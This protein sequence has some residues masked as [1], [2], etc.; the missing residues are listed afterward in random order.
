MSYGDEFDND[1]YDDYNHPQKQQEM[2]DGVSTFTFSQGRQ[3][4]DSFKRAS[5]SEK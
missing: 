2:R 4:S 3:E 5:G 1:V